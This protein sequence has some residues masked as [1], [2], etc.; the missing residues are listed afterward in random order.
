LEVKVVPWIIDQG[1]SC[2]SS[3]CDEANSLD[4]NSAARSMRLSGLF[5][6]VRTLIYPTPSISFF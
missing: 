2:D 4:S 3:I 1:F 5:L 6:N